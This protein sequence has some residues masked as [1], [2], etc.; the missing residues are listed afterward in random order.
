MDRSPELEELSR[1]WMESM[2]DGDAAAFEGLL[3]TDD[4]V[5]FI[6]SDPQEWWDDRGKIV[7][8][9]RAQ[10]AEMKGKIQVTPN[11]VV[12]YAEDGWGWAALNCTFSAGGQDSSFRI[13]IVLKRR[14]DGWKMVHGH[15]SA[16]VPNEDTVGITLTT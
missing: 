8:A 1:R 13:S 3:D 15:A 11:D 14:D 9:F 2:V 16:G 6:G 5:L 12:A 7:A 10:L 4:S